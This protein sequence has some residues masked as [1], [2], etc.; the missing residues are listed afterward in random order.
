VISVCLKLFWESFNHWPSNTF[1]FDP[2]NLNVQ[3]VFIG[4]LNKEKN[5]E[6]SLIPF[7]FLFARIIYTLM[8]VV[9]QQTIHT[10]FLLPER[11]VR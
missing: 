3:N 4:M 10:G 11:P 6:N 5:K 1:N 9:W 2:I 7:L 8:H